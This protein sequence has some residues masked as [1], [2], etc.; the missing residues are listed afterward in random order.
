LDSLSSGQWRYWSVSDA[1][2]RKLATILDSLPNGFPPTPDGLEIRLLKKIFTPDEAELFCDLKLGPETVEQIAQRTGR[3]LEG[4][5]EKLTSMCKRGEVMGVDLGGIKLFAMLPWV[6]GIY[7]FQ[8]NRLDREFCELCEEYGQYIGPHLLG[9]GPQVMQTI[10]IEEQI[11]ARQEA[12]PYEMVS[13]II[14]N[15]KG[16]RV[17]DCIC[18][19]ERGILGEP[20]SKPHEVCLAISPV[21]GAELILDWGRPISK[22][23]AYDI[24]HKSEEAGLVHLT[25][26]VENGHLFIC[27]CCGCCCGVLRT[28]NEFNLTNVINSNFYAVIDEDACDGCAVCVDE[29]CQVKAIEQTAISYRVITDRCIGC[30]LCVTACPLGAVRL[31]RKPQDKIIRPPSDPLAWNDERARHR[32]VDYSAYK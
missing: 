21:E 17:N 6:V 23:E 24:L 19:K 18:K 8:I 13:S 3:P 2:Y 29:R 15:G 7:E 4:L 26:N 32:A 9:V 12:L 10:P 16:F 31:V 11:P 20:C 30:G 28:M 5:E 1:I 27:N 22:Q 25:S 14:E